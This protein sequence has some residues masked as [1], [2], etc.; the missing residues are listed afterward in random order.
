VV[1]IGFITGIEKEA[2]IIRE[3]TS[4][5]DILCAGANSDNAYRQANELAKNGCDILV[6]FGVAGALDPMLTSGD[7]IL[8]RSVTNETGITFEVD[9][10]L[11]QIVTSHLSEYFKISSG[12]LYGSN[13][14]ISDAD[15]KQKLNHSLGTTA[16]DMESFGVA[17][18]AQENDCPFLI[19]RAIAD[20]A[21]Q[22][23]P[24]ASLHAI[25]QNGNIKIGQVMID[26]A[27]KPSDL[28]GLI[29]L[30]SNS[31]KA[32]ASLSRVALFGFGF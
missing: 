17:K 19:V 20:M 8:P 22:S 29:K 28:W 11:N 5:S 4:Y 14:V 10:D 25:D 12:I 18:A 24:A 30:G 32:F 6:S 23:L 7:I 3:K 26:L 15:E 1:R 21:Q 9:L 2:A 13:T 16:V 27:K 31:R